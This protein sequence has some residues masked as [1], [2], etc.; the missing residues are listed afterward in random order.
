MKGYRMTLECGCEEVWY[1]GSTFPGVGGMSECMGSDTENTE[2]G[3]TH[4]MQ[5]IVEVWEEEF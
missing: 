4:G 2:P 5:K 3:E 1:D